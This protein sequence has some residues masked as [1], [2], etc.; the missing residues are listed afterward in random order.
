MAKDLE[1]QRRR[2]VREKSVIDHLAREVH[3]PKSFEKKKKP[4]KPSPITSTGLSVEEQVRKEW[5]PR[6]GG[7]PTF[8]RWGKAMSELPR[9]LPRD[10]PDY[11][12]RQAAHLRALAETAT[13]RAVKDRLLHEAERYEELAEEVAGAHAE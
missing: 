11:H 3:N 1:A 9:A 2:H 8:F 7:L 6:K 5:D 4:D 10:V 13:T 12:Q